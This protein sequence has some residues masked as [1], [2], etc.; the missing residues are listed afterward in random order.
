MRRSLTLL[1]VLSILSLP[2]LAQAADGPG[3]SLVEP[4]AAEQSVEAP[5]VALEQGACQ[6]PAITIPALTQAD[7]QEM[8][9]PSCWQVDGSY[10]SN[11]GSW[12][13][14]QWTPYEPEI[15]VCQSNHTWQCPG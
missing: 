7:F 3:A 13:R 6:D 9:F 10:C 5:A 12:T 1:A 11:P 2:A 14:C 8:A 4:A 15:C